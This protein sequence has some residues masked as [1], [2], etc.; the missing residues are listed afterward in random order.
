MS[1]RSSRLARLC[2]PHATYPIPT[3]YFVRSFISTI[4]F[5]Q[6]YLV[7]L[8]SESRTLLLS[9]FEG[10]E[11][12][13]LVKDGMLCMRYLMGEFV[14]SWRRD[15]R[16]AY[17]MTGNSSVRERHRCLHQRSKPLYTVTLGGIESENGGRTFRETLLDFSPV[18][19]Q[20]GAV[21]DLA[22]HLVGSIS[23]PE[24][25]VLS[26]TYG[27][28]GVTGTHLVYELSSSSN[29]RSVSSLH[30]FSFSRM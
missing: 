3:P 17:A 29:R 2:S 7:V 16:N 24:R 28:R 4:R 5:P 13:Y 1:P 10:R 22:E 19:R 27:P 11:P 30:T 14:A 18:Q 15:Y 8:Q 9:V 6:S 12:A 26:A 23:P 21:K 20:T 25:Q